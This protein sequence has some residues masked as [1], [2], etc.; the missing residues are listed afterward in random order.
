[1]SN[2]HSASQRPAGS[3]G[4]STANALLDNA[5]LPTLGRLALP[6]MLALS[7]QSLAVMAE[8]RFIGLIGTEALAAMAL[9]FPTIA[10]TQMLSAGAMGGGVS[11]AIARAL[12]AGNEARARTL[13]LHALAIGVAAGIVMSALFVSL[14]AP[15]YALLGGRGT[16]LALAIDYAGAFFSGALA[17]WLFNTLVSVVRGTGNM[18]LPSAS[19]VAVAALQVVL[20]AVLSLGLG[21]FPRLGLV[22]IALAQV[23]AFGAGAAFLLWHLASGSARLRLS[24]AGTRFDGHLFW[25][26]LKVGAV[27]CLS[28][29]QSI[30]VVIILARL[31]ANYGTTALAGFGIG[32]RLEL[33]LVP[34]AFAIGIACVPMVGMAIGAQQIDRARRIAWTGAALSGALIGAI[35]LVIAWQPW[36]WGRIYT[37]DEAVLGAVDTYLGIAGFGF[38]AYGFG[39]CLYF[40]SQ[41]SGKILGPVIGNTMRLAGVIAGGWWLVQG[42]GSFVA[43]A[44]LIAGTLILYGATVGLAVAMTRW[45]PQPA[46]KA[47]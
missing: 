27:A 13:A 3:S 37:S 23:L 31:A 45:G 19:L 4:P 28:P 32:V 20:G 14:R 5:I 1:M 30:L 22:G 9:V 18:R 6:N 11:S 7:T 10:L 34:I 12:G 29:I 44:W 8:T 42:G 24:I 43:L 39:L 33:L 35:G 16:V 26:I 17:I 47:A 2:E 41:G 40:A 25:D 46:L 38:P 15:L 36:L 21:P